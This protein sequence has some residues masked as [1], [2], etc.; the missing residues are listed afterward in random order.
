VY[1]RGASFDFTTESGIDPSRT[2]RFRVPHTVAVGISVRATPRLLVSGEVTRIG[3]SRL[4]D[5]FVT[6]Q[7]RATGRPESFTIDDG[8]EVHVSAQYALIRQGGGSPL[9]LRVGAWYDPDHSLKFLRTRTRMTV[10]D[11]L[12]DERL[13]AALSQGSNQTHI[14]GGVGFTINPRLE[15]NAGF[16]AA[17]RQRLLSTSLIVHLREGP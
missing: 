3:Y 16:D 14:T 4:V 5:E 2:V 11:R 17:S 1:R 6:D 9:R 13:G 12:F 10:D 8:T 15:F 7:A